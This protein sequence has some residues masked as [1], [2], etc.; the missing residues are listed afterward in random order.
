MPQKNS[1]SNTHGRMMKSAYAVHNRV[2]FPFILQPDIH[3][4]RCF[5]MRSSG[6]Q[7]RGVGGISGESG[8]K[9][10]TEV[11]GYQ[12][13]WYHLRFFTR[14]DMVSEPLPMLPALQVALPDHLAP[15]PGKHSVELHS[16]T[17]ALAYKAKTSQYWGRLE[18][19]PRDRLAFAGDLAAKITQ[20]VKGAISVEYEPLRA[21]VR[22]L[23]ISAAFPIQQCPALAG[24]DAVV[25]LDAAEGLGLHLRVPL[26]SRCPEVSMS[27]VRVVAE[28]R[29]LLLGYHAAMRRCVDSITAFTTLAKEK[30]LTIA[31]SKSIGD[32][33]VRL[34]A[35]ASIEG[36]RLVRPKVGWV[37]VSSV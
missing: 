10:S 7:L 33:S 12:P 25:K 16:A 13:N 23:Q 8:I 14:W 31:A 20:R 27:D 28:R 30:T 37:I 11:A 36:C 26:R 17:C 2:V 19:V 3:H 18:V 1:E 15:F 6:V 5:H 21:G 9:N 29:R 32:C 35:Q 24:S 34:H 4:G 22:K